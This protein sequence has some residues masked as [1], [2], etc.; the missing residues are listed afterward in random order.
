MV[1]VNEECMIHYFEKLEKQQ[2]ETK[3]LESILSILEKRDLFLRFL[4]AA[5]VDNW[6]G[7]DIAI[8]MRDNTE[9]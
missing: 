3:R 4:E 7:Y 9:L 1:K 8:E 2:A 6:D 5:G